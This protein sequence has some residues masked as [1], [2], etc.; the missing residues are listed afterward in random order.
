M[1]S[2]TQLV[3]SLTTIPP[4]FPT[5]GITLESILSQ[6]LRPDRVELH[7]PRTYRRFREH[8]FHLPKVPEGVEVVVADSD[9][10][11]ATKVLP[12]ALRHRGSNTRIIYCDDDRICPPGWTKLLVKK[13]LER[14]QDCIVNAGFEIE[15]L[16]MPVHTPKN[17]KPQ[18]RAKRRRGLNHALYWVDRLIHQLKTRTLSKPPRKQFLTDG[19]LDIGEGCGGVSVSPEF[20]DDYAFD[21]PDV[22]WAVDDVWLSGCLARNGTRI[23]VDAA[24]KMPAEHSG[25]SAAL[26]KAVLDGCDRHDADRACVEHFRMKYGIW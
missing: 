4:R 13:S 15:L 14:P 18:P 12:S 22:L 19:Y 21:I 11:P 10:G 26:W 2:S 1:R 23:W 6:R 8:S 9:L 16:G 20:F 24:G 25:T 5:V 3:V 7:V 17:P